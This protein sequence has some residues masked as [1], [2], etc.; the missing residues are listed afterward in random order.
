MYYSAHLFNFCPRSDQ[1]RRKWMYHLGIYQ[2][3]VWSNFSKS[4]LLKLLKSKKNK[5]SKKI[6]IFCLLVY[7]FKEKKFQ[8]DEFCYLLC[9]IFKKMS[10]DLVGS[11]RSCPV[12]KLIRPVRLSPRRNNLHVID[13]SSTPTYPPGLVNVV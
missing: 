1:A 13:I 6:Q 11:N 12:R 2:N 5:I 3:H 9:Q 8:F 4:G 10:P 7:F